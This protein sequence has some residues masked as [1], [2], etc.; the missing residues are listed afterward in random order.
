M[1]KFSIVRE[2]SEILFQLHISEKTERGIDNGISTLKKY[3]FI[4]W[5]GSNRSG[6]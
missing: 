3:G 4:E 1:G 2:L 6:Y 5:V